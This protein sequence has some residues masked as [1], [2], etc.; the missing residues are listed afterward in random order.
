MNDKELKAKD[1]I[2]I[3]IFSALIIAVEFACGMLGFIHPYIVAAYVVL[4]PLV[5]SIP[6]MLFYTKIEK[7]GKQYADKLIAEL[8][9]A[10]FEDTHPMALSGGQKQRT[11]ICS[12]LAANA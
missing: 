4:I 9:L 11:A 6:M 12:A 7:F 2:T 5:G 1:F 8:G 3:G 10:G